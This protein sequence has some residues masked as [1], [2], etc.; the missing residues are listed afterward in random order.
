M[1]L[2]A[3]N[4]TYDRCAVA[5]VNNSGRRPKLAHEKVF[6]KNISHHPQSLIKIRLWPRLM[7]E[8]T[9]E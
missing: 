9:I 4:S 2:A 6:P 5:L 7:N 8:L 3:G 1:L